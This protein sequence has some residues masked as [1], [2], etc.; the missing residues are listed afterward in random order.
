[1]GRG[2][3]RGARVPCRV[4]A[5]SR[6]RPRAA[7]PAV[8]VRPLRGA[9]RVWAGRIVVA[10]VALDVSYLTV[11]RSGR[12]LEWMY[13]HRISRGNYRLTNGR[14]SWWLCRDRGSFQ[15]ARRHPE[16]PAEAP[17]EIR[18]HQGFEPDEDDVRERIEA[19]RSLNADMEVLLAKGLTLEDAHLATM[20]SA[21]AVA[22]Q[23]GLAYF[24]AFAVAH[25]SLSLARDVGA[26]PE[27][28]A[29]QVTAH[30][31]PA[32]RQRRVRD[33]LDPI[34]RKP[35]GPHDL[36]EYEFDDMHPGP[37]PSS[38]ASPRATSTAASTPR[39]R[40]PPPVA[41]TDSATATSPW[42]VVRRPALPRR[43]EPR[44]HRPRRPR[45]LG[46]APRRRPRLPDPPI[47]LAPPRSGV[48]PRVP[49]LARIYRGPVR[50]ETTGL[51]G[52]PDILQ[53]FIPRG[54]P[55]PKVVGSPRGIAP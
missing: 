6:R 32:P 43:P 52:G 8:G 41:S 16:D 15:I 28:A 27:S 17:R 46:Q 29:A 53:L 1:M 35:A 5:R 34:A 19:G 13:A 18:H 50:A 20:R 12:F 14:K 10:R 30:D 25:A 31:E 7:G 26:D 11:L 3:L 33:H 42:P 39:R 36:V 21:I 40:S 51:V 22:Q 48:D 37:L 54:G 44:P 47:R 38:P 23:L 45:R 55:A 4:A 2:R 24:R 49:R 9:V